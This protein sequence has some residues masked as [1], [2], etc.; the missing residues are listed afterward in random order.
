MHLSEFSILVLVAYCALNF[1]FALALHWHGEQQSHLPLRVVDLLVHFVL[2]TA[3]AVPVLVV[4][5]G[6]AMFGGKP[7]RRRAGKLSL[8]RTA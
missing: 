1:L 7:M 4:V 5:A 8:V 6:E 2:M 3:F